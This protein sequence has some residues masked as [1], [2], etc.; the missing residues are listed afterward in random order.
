[1][2]V[3]ISRPSGVNVGVMNPGDTVYITGDAN[4][5]KS[6]RLHGHVQPDGR[7]AVFVEEMRDGDDF[8]VE[9]K[10]Q[11]DVTDDLLGA[12]IVDDNSGD[13]VESLDPVPVH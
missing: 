12:V 8:L 7:M 4:T 5:D 6:L 3:V 13:V 11:E 9:I 10:A 1:M 2:S